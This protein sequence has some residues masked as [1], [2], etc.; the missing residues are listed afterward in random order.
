MRAAEID[1]IVDAF[2]QKVNTRQHERLPLK[3]V[4]QFLRMPFS[5]DNADSWTDWQI[6]KADNSE[7]IEDLET[8]IGRRFPAGYRSL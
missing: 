8:R 2:V 4:P 7:A 6:H 1:E 3:D 5:G